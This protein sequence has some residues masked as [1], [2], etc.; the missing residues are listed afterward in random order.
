MN[1]L[2]VENNFILEENLTNH[3]SY[4]KPV[5]FHF[6][7]KKNQIKKILSLK[8]FDLIIVS[9][10]LPNSYSFDVVEEFFLNKYKKIIIQI[11]EKKKDKK[12]K[13]SNFY[14]IKPIKINKIISIIDKIQFLQH[15]YGL[16]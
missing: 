13:S 12:H 14:F 6:L 3:L 7:S 15:E 11:S 5:N 16:Y 1:L 8:K 10:L 4:D 2:I 9:S